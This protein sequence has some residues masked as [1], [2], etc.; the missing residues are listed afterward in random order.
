MPIKAK[1]DEP[2]IDLVKARTEGL[3][4]LSPLQK[5]MSAL[6]VKTETDY[7]LAD[8][9]LGEVDGAIKAWLSKV[10]PP[11]S[12]IRQ[13]LDLLYELK[14]SVWNP[15]KDLKADIVKK[16]KGFKEEER[17][18]LREAEEGRQREAER[19]RL[20]AQALLAKEEM[21]KTKARQNQLI[22]QIAEVE[23]Q[24][25]EVEQAPAEAPVKGAKSS[26][27]YPLKCRVTDLGLLMA[28]I[29]ESPEDLT[30]LVEVNIS[31]LDA[32]R[33]LQQAPIG[34]WLPGVE[35]FEDIQIAGRGR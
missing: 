31:Q 11:I 14:N 32:L 12:H 8:Q 27:R 10:D 13:G 15:L 28:H 24:I 18:L 23:Q 20:E 4:I 17:R 33:R 19:L 22:E 2:K 34:N 35:V 26:T 1:A 5:R 29:L 3:T 9:A 6:Q 7:L 25:A 30:S 16:M 21:A